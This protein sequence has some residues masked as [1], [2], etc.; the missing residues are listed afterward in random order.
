MRE[1]RTSFVQAICVM[2]GYAGDLATRMNQYWQ[3]SS[4]TE[5]FLTIGNTV[6]E[7]N[8]DLQHHGLRGFSQPGKSQ[9]LNG[10]I[11][12]VRSSCIVGMI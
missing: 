10:T 4:K 2:D 12:L 7:A 3:Q 1:G 9:R 5:P 6:L 8:S 11:A